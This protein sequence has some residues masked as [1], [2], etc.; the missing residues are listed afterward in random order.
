MEYAKNDL[1][2]HH[3]LAALSI[4]QVCVL[5]VQPVV[6]SHFYLL[7]QPFLKHRVNSRFVGNDRYLLR[8]CRWYGC[9]DVRTAQAIR[10]ILLANATTA[11]LGGRLFSS[12]SAQ[13]P[14]S[15]AANSTERAPWINKVRS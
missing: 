7:A 5:A 10:T 6:P 8:Y 15:F 2:S 4:Y 3:A 9:P 13:A 12:C 14:F 1:I 11:T